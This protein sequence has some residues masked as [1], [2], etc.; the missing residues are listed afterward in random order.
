M[1]QL[2]PNFIWP[3]IGNAFLNHRQRPVV[4]RYPHEAIA[5]I[6]IRC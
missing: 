1:V 4:L 5:R 3:L 2:S 6:R